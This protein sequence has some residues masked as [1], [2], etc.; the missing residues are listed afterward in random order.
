MLDAAIVAR[1]TCCALCPALSGNTQVRKTPG[2]HDQAHR[3]S[4][5]ANL[6]GLQSFC[7]HSDPVV[8]PRLPRFHTGCGLFATESHGSNRRLERLKIEMFCFIHAGA[9]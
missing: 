3:A 7:F 5:K 1:V 4:F 9:I 6:G 8:V 2:K